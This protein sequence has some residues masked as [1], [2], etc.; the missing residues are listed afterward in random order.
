MD[1]MISGDDRGESRE[2]L[3]T[4]LAIVGQQR[5]R[6]TSTLDMIMQ[7]SFDVIISIDSR[8]VITGVSAGA[9]R[10]LGYTAAEM[11]GQPVA[12]YL[13]PG[14]LL[15][16]EQNMRAIADG[17]PVQRYRTQRTRK[18]GTLVDIVSTVAPIKNAANEIVG[19]VAIA[20]DLTDIH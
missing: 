19:A 5:D 4:R 1:N 3:L 2:E 6:V 7:A 11:L 18:D 20:Q 14:Q 17:R 9:E 12:D 8:H 10:A 16:F 15:E 13:E